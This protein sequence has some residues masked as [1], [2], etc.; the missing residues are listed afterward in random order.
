MRCAARGR[1]GRPGIL[2]W[3]TTAQG[4][5][6]QGRV[7]RRGRRGQSGG[8]TT[9]RNFDHRRAYKRADRQGRRG[10]NEAC[11]RWVEGSLE[12]FGETFHI[13]WLR[14]D[15]QGYRQSSVSF[16]VLD[17]RMLCRQKIQLDAGRSS[18]AFTRHSGPITNPPTTYRVLPLPHV[19]IRSRR[20]N[21]VLYCPTGL[22]PGLLAVLRQ[23][24]PFTV[25]NT[26][27]P[28]WTTYLSTNLWRTWILLSPTHT[29]T[30]LHPSE[31]YHSN[32][33]PRQKIECISFPTKIAG[34]QQSH[35]SRERRWGT[36][37]SSNMR[38]TILGP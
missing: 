20:R 3:R 30:L 24:N 12:R 18:A 10:G 33:D 22:L 19:M 29:R 26:R 38:P 14:K 1:P 16:L 4:A 9:G 8:R 15:G 7:G 31:S 6:G 21:T 5:V 11:W 2:C 13:W 34:H 27:R 17:C 35:R 32:G 36:Y 23:G 28:T 37:H 25:V